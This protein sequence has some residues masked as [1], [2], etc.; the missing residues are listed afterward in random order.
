MICLIYGTDR[1]KVKTE[2]ELLVAAKRAKYPELTIF[3]FDADKYDPAQLEE[4]IVGQTLFDQK[5]VAVFDGLWSLAGELLTRSLVAMLNSTNLYLLIESEFDS[6]LVKKIVAGGGQI[7][8]I[9]AA[10]RAAPNQPNLFAIADAL[11]ERDRK[12]SW[13]LFIE[14]SRRGAAA[15]E[16]FWKI[17]W[18]VKTMLLVRKTPDPDRLELKPFVL[19][20][21]RR[22][23]RN[24]ADQELEKLSARLVALWHDSRRGVTDFELGLERLLLEI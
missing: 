24:F 17:V 13:T 19:N 14:A 2:A 20:Q 3:R 16:I 4:V 9:K 10:P 21:A 6:R 5:F 22:H 7:K 8:A 11:G 23:G 1:Q 12:K 15:E 18:K